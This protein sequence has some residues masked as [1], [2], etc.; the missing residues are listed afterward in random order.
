[1]G[2][3]SKLSLLNSPI[4]TNSGEINGKNAYLMSLTSFMVKEL[5]ESR[6]NMDFYPVE[7]LNFSDC[8]KIHDGML[9]L[10][11]DVFTADGK[12]TTGVYVL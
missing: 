7:G 12:R 9:M 3:S 8:I 1:M 2:V 5:A 4:F 11:Y 6:G 10:F